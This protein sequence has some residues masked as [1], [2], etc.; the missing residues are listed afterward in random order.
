MG[1]G[2]RSVKRAVEGCSVSDHAC[3]S[4]DDQGNLHALVLNLVFV[5]VTNTLFHVI[6]KKQSQNRKLFSSKTKR[7]LS[8]LQL[9]KHTGS[10]A[11]QLTWS[12]YIMGA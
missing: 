6:S 5:K 8:I 3:C 11:S 2:E 12:R 9:R 1:W 7:N 4:S 10:Q